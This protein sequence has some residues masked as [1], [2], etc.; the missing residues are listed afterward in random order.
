MLRLYKKAG[1]KVISQ[2]GSHVK[3]AKDSRREIIPMHKELKKGIEQAL[4]KRLEQY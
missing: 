4:L 3:V 2:K 1:W